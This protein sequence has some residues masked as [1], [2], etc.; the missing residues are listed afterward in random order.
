VTSREIDFEFETK[1]MMRA[2]KRLERHMHAE[3]HGINGKKPTR[4]VTIKMIDAY[5]D[6]WNAASGLRGVLERKS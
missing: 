4:R 2:V 6:V 3:T 1:R 5:C